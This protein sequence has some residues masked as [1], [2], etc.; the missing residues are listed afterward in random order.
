MNPV[1]EIATLD[2]SPDGAEILAECLGI[3]PELRLR[4]EGACMEPALPR[5]VK[6]V[7]ASLG[8]H[9]PRMGDIVLVR[10]PV[11]LRVHR[12]VWAW[13]LSR[14]AWRTKG[15]RSYAFDS[16]LLPGAVLGTVVAPSE[17]GLTR[18]RRTLWSLVA[19][20]VRRIRGGL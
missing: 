4:V 18:W 19:G 3:F 20:S 2:R 15:D 12:L 6:V 10:M 13:P 8:L 9:R 11:G 7:V 1:S 16:A 5:G 17:A 14:G